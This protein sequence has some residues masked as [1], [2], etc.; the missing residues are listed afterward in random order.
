[1]TA[2]DAAAAATRS[3]SPRRPLRRAGGVRRV[4]AAVVGRATGCGITGTATSMVGEIDGSSGWSVSGRDRR[5][6]SA[7]GAGISRRGRSSARAGSASTILVAGTISSGSGS[8][9]TGAVGTTGSTAGSTSSGGA[10]GAAGAARGRS[11]VA[12]SRSGVTEGVTSASGTSGDTPTS[13]L[14]GDGRVTIRASVSPVGSIAR[15]RRNVDARA[16]AGVVGADSR[17]RA[18]RA[19]S[20]STRTSSGLIPERSSFA[21]SGM[22]ATDVI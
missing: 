6:G 14:L 1:M 5:T 13:P 12:R 9:S 3:A 16:S 21:S 4:G 15:T 18:R 22:S 11:S 10:A 2:T 8:T 19:S 17:S 7:R 20:G